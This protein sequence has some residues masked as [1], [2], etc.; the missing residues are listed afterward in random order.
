MTRLRSHRRGSSKGRPPRSR[1]GSRRASTTSCRRF[2]CAA[3][4]RRRGG[5][6]PH[7]A[8]APSCSGDGWTQ[9][10]L[11]S[12]PRSSGGSP[13]SPPPE[14]EAAPSPRRTRG[15]R[16]GRSRQAFHRFAVSVVAD[17][18]DV[19]EPAFGLGPVAQ[20]S[21]VVA[22]LAV[23]YV[24]PVLPRQAR[25]SLTVTFP[26]GR[27]SA[28]ATLT[29]ELAS[30]VA[31]GRRRSGGSRRDAPTT[32]GRR[33]S[34]S[35]RRC[36]RPHD[37]RIRCSSFRT[38]AAA[39]SVTPSVRA[40]RPR[41]AAG[42]DVPEPLRD[43][44]RLAD[45]RGG[46]VQRGRPLA[47]PPR[48]RAA[49]RPACRF[50]HGRHRPRASPSERV[51]APRLGA[52]V[53]LDERED[54]SPPDVHPQSGRPDVLRDAREPL[55]LVVSP[56]PGEQEPEPPR[57]VCRGVLVAE[58][59]RALEARPEHTLGGRRRRPPSPRPRRPRSNARPPTAGGPAP[60]APAGS[61]PTS[62][63]A[64]SNSPSLRTQ[65]TECAQR[66]RVHV[67]RGGRLGDPLDA[68]DRRVDRDAAPR[69]RDADPADDVVLDVAGAC[70]SRVLERDRTAAPPDSGSRARSNAWNR[71]SSAIASASW[72]PA[73]ASTRTTSSISRSSCSC[74]R[75]A[76]HRAPGRSRASP[77]Q[78]AASSPSSVATACASASTVAGG[79]ALAGP[80][81]RVAE[82]E[83]ELHALGRLARQELA[84]ALQAAT[85]PPPC[86]PGRYA[87][88][89][90]A[91]QV[92]RR[93]GRELVDRRA[94]ALP[95]R[96]ARVRPAR[97]GS[98]AD[99][100]PSVPRS[101]ARAARRS[102]SSARRRF[103]MLAVGDVA[104][105]GVPERPASGAE[106]AGLA[107]TDELSPDERHQ[108]R[109]RVARPRA[110]RRL[111][112]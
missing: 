9:S 12:S 52:A 94:A 17:H 40:E 10:S 73:C 91:P 58:L 48:T 62:A 61:P 44:G 26:R 70:L 15:S 99:T 45:E 107:G 75:L 89:A 37:W 111:R 112:S 18:G 95:S 32:A 14:T 108:R 83:Q 16:G 96:A 79:I 13:P 100:S 104:D 59:V 19:I 71:P 3:G 11:G 55:R 20:R 28:A 50:P 110:P 5:A 103:G 54:D 72:S 53:R 88:D 8:T 25:Y 36:A 66:G 33:P 86:P 21:A 80:R 67:R 31:G 84:R 41:R 74:A 56:L 7:R 98:P 85:T 30:E 78:S 49:R 2:S 81:E 101:I 24:R 82:L 23:H 60:P 43:P 29:Y 90:R 39:P 51:H 4:S 1:L 22:P 105:E 93:T 6:S 57:D 34:E 42:D 92:H 76:P 77:T 46:L 27:G 106:I 63:L 65:E 102:C 69:E 35:R 68:C 38:A 87:D 97:G 109:G 64:S 47:A